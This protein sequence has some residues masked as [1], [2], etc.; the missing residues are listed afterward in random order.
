MK[1]I[2]LDY[3]ATTPVHPQVATLMEKYTKTHFGN[4]SSSHWFG[5]KAKEGV[6]KAR[7]Q[8]ASLLGS[9]PE[10]IVFTSGGTE[11]NNFAIRCAAETFRHK[12]NHI[13]TTRIEHPAVIKP[14]RYLEQHGFEVTYL[15]VDEYGR[16]NPLE[17]K[18]AIKPSTILITIMHANNE[19]GT[20]Q[21][22]AK[23]SEIAKKKNI[24]VHTDAA[25][26]VGKIPAKV[27]NLGVD[28]LSIA[29]HKLYAPKGVGA[30]Y[31]RKGITIH[32]FMLGAG[33]ESG[34]RAGTENVIEITGLGK[35][36]E[37]LEKKM[38]YNSKRI[39]ELRD[40]L[41]NGLINAGIKVKLNGH[42]KHRLPNTLNVSFIGADSHK[43]LSKI[44]GIAVSTGS[45]C[46][47]DSKEP[48]GILTAMGIRADV[49][50]GAVR[51]SLGLWTTGK[52][53]DF[54]VKK[55]KEVLEHNFLES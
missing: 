39:K 25:Q 9:L 29:G 35:A 28:F 7:K 38:E 16:V 24:L 50:F 52:E 6:E 14:C 40:K 42:L 49:A 43:L 32:P 31:I 23:I 45:A 37:I 12:G 8:V 21:P 20:I 53:I 11:S 10:E 15:P 48:S 55:I 47:A 26:S 30:L 34:R 1:R 22:I 5:I 27:K 54:V 18:K 33:H 3:N 17:V 51:F 36:C 13:I 41:Y 2:Y 19:V 46:H 44:P 4:P